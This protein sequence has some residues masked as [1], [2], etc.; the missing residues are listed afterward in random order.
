MTSIEQHYL[1][2]AREANAARAGGLMKNAPGLL[3][4]GVLAPTGVQPWPQLAQTQVD[5]ASHRGTR[6]RATG[7]P[8]AQ[9]ERTSREMTRGDKAQW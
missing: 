2:H 8:E 5:R 7:G 1:V 4:Q 6:G 9:S 3:G